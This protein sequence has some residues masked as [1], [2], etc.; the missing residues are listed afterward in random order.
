METIGYGGDRGDSVCRVA[1]PRTMQRVVCM[2][3]KRVYHAV[4]PNHVPVYCKFCQSDYLTWN[5]V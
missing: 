3:C 2:D 1:Q 5:K 4:V